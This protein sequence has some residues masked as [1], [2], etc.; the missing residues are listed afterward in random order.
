MSIHSKLVQAVSRKTIK[1]HGLNKDQ[2]LK[3]LRTVFNNTPAVPLIPRGVKI[4]RIDLPEFKGERVSVHNP[5]MTILYF[6]GGA[7]VG[8]VTKTYHN[9]AARLAKQLKAEV[10]LAT[11]PLAPEAPFP[12]ATERCLEAYRYLLRLDKDPKNIVIAG[13]SAGGSLAL[14]SLLQIKDNQLPNPRCAVLLSPATTALPEEE[15]LLAQCPTDA[16]LSA[17]LVKRIIDLYLPN[18]E[19]RSHPYASPLFGDYTGL[20]PI[21]FMASKDEI[22]YHDALQAKDRAIAAGVDVEWFARSGVCHVW[23]IMVP[24]LPEANRDLKR[25]IRFIRHYEPTAKSLTEHNRHSQYLAT[26][27]ATA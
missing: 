25:I 4:R 2:T 12:A 23:P 3:H 5:R 14:T 19:D 11:Y 18:K 16:M 10:F 9:L 26:A 27:G 21:M 17:T 1:R 15:K 7:F 20:P 8:G 6:H 13:D 24:F 22:L